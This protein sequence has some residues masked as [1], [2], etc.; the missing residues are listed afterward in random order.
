MGLIQ[1]REPKALFQYFEEISAIPRMSYREA[2]IADYLETF[3][4]K[5][6][7]ACYRDPHHNVLI[8]MPATVGYED[9]APVLLQGHS[10]MVC[11]KNA[12]VEHD[13]LHDPL[14]LYLDGDHLRARGT[15]LGADDGIAMAIM[16]AVLDGALS[17]HPTV[18]CLFTS[19]EEVGL[20][21]AKTFDYSLIKARR[22]INLDSESLGVITAGCAGGIRS[23]IC[24]PFY[25][26]PFSGWALRVSVKG[27]AG[28]HSGE[29]IHEGRANANKIMGRL[30]A[31]LNREHGVT[32]ANVNGGSKDNAIPREC[33]ALISVCDRE[34]AETILTDT[35][36][37]IAR[38]L[39]P[40]D[41]QFTVTVEDAETE[42]FMLSKPDSN[43][44]V[45]LLCGT[46]NGVFEMNR[47]IEGLVEYSRNLGVVSTE[48]DHVKF[49]F[50][51]RSAMESRLDA[52]IT[53]LDALALAFGGTAKHYARYPGWEFAQQSPLRDAYCKAYKEVTGKDAVI[54]VIHAGLECGIIYANVPSLDVISIAPNLGNLHS[55]DEYLDLSSVEVFWKTFEKIMKDL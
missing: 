16:L 43:R 14:D 25:G 21:G 48:A 32:V 39:V 29:N 42:A 4:K 8:R 51:S 17:E 9:H 40:L 10:D 26:I 3:A 55:P 49:I 45:A 2:E 31:T 38:E 11:E 36:I 22:M 18:E 44:V 13:F 35:A 52:S 30:L 28:G 19:A 7:L 27:L 24:L 15:T 33:T 23:E 5:R 46:P 37:A 54:K 47:S 1:G 50:A 20:D 34:E 6:G 41:R 12:D 53:E